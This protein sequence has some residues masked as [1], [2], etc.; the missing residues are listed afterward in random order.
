MANT[1]Q[2]CNASLSQARSLCTDHKGRDDHY[3]NKDTQ[4]FRLTAARQANKYTERLRLTE[5]TQANKN[6]NPAR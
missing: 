6:T 3:N 2:S 4:R 1:L 5:H